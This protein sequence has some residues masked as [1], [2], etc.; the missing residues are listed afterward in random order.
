MLELLL[1]LSLGSSITQLHP[2]AQSLMQMAQQSGEA[3]S[4]TPAEAS[5]REGVGFHQQG[6]VDQAIQAYQAAIDLDPQLDSAYINLSLLFI[7]IG[8]LDRAETLLQKAL[9]LPDRAE[10]PASVHAIA[11]YNLAVI[12]SRQDNAAA[13]L[14]AVQQALVIAPDFFQAQQFLDQLRD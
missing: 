3:E 12:R 7:S 4:I 11:H 1:S 9:A 10:L 8:E 5:Y 2:Q 6:Q 13:A 14:K